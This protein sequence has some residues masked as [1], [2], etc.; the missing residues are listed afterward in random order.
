MFGMS[1]PKPRF[2]IIFKQ[3]DVF[4][5]A[6]E[7][8]IKICRRGFIRRAAGFFLRKDLGA[9]LANL[10]NFHLIFYKILFKPQIFICS[11]LTTGII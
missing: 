9:V 1:M 3:K 11:N 5:P 8:L 7:A 6:G 2:L 4:H 10:L